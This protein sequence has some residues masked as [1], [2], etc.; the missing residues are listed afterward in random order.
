ML[1]GWWGGGWGGGSQGSSAQAEQ[2]GRRASQPFIAGQ[3]DGVLGSGLRGRGWGGPGGRKPAVLARPP[4]G[5]FNTPAQEEGRWGP[6]AQIS[7]WPGVKS[8]PRPL[9]SPFTEKERECGADGPLSSG[10][11]V[12]GVP[13]P[14]CLD[15]GVKA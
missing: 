9:S 6:L 7:W 5:P 14:G 1:A 2:E 3:R 12:G 15:R 10:Q 4:P 11:G 13:F 8:G